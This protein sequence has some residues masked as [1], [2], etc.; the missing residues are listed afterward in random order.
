MKIEKKYG[1]RIEV[2]RNRDGSRVVYVSHIE[3][4]LNGEYR[5][6]SGLTL[7]PAQARKVAEALR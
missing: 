4:G 6:G 2:V 3:A 1:D 7:T 5:V